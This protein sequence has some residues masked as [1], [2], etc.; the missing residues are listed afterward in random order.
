M[1]DKTGENNP[2]WRGISLRPDGRAFVTIDGKRFF[3][4]R[5]VME[6]HLGRAL[7]S[8]EIVHHINGDPSD[9]RIENLQV[10]Q[11]HKAHLKLHEEDAHKWRK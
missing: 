1:R 6:N 11:G 8:D 3:R 9:D 2:N 5:T 4:A 10:I 7:E